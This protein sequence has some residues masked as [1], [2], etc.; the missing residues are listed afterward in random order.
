MCSKICDYI[1]N[2]LSGDGDS[3]RYVLYGSKFNCDNIY[4]GREESEL[5]SVN[6]IEEEEK[7]VNK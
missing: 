3:R 1:L 2:W 5:E 7:L 4:Y 6:R